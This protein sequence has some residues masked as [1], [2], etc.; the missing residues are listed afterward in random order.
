MFPLGIIFIYVFS[1]VLLGTAK[2]QRKGKIFLVVHVSDISY[3][4]V[5]HSTARSFGNLNITSSV[6]VD[7]GMEIKPLLSTLVTIAE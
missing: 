4:F 7:A 2:I 1:S 6:L 5:I 3:V